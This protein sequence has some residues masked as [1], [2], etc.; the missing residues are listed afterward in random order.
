MLQFRSSAMVV[1]SRRGGGRWGFGRVNCSLCTWVCR[2]TSAWSASGN[3]QPAPEAAATVDGQQPRLPE[4]TVLCLCTS[5]TLNKLVGWQAG[6]QK[7]GRVFLVD[8]LLCGRAILGI[9]CVNSSY[10]SSSTGDDMLLRVRE[11]C[12]SNAWEF[13]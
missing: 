1:H 6:A 11:A 2:R 9:S 12:K 8:L 4:H 10:R 5:W 3:L 13:I 7:A